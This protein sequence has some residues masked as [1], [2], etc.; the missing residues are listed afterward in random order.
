MFQAP[1]Y[2]G[3]SIE[4]MLKFADKYNLVAQALPSEPREVLKL[5]RN[6]VSSVIYSL[7]GEPFAKWV[8]A[9]IKERNRKIEEKQDMLAQLDPEIAEI[10][11]AS[12]SVSGKLEILSRCLLIFIFIRVLM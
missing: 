5:H 11:K 4:E 1:Q 2:D 7:V 6:Y 3:L 9:R 12:T 8:I 10:L